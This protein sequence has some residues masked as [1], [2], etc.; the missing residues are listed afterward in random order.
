[1]NIISKFQNFKN[2]LLQISP[3]FFVVGLVLSLTFFLLAIDSVK[4][5]RSEVLILVNLKSETAI[6]QQEQLLDTIV[7]LPKTLAFYDQIL[8]KNKNVR[9]VSENLDPDKRKDS[10]NKMLSI[11]RVGKNSLIFKISISTKSASDSEQLSSKTVRELFDRIAF[12]YDIKKD[13]DLRIIEKP[14]ARTEVS[15]WPWILI[16]SFAGGFGIAIVLNSLLGPAVEK[17]TE[18]KEEN[19]S[20]FVFD[21]GKKAKVSVGQGVEKLR[22]LYQSDAPFVFEEK[23][24]TFSGISQIDPQLQEMKKLTKQME[25]SKYPNFPEMPVATKVKASAPDNLPIAEDDFLA[26]LPEIEKE[27][28]KEPVSDE[29]VVDFK[30]EPTKEELKER[31]NQLLRG[32]F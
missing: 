28:P 20:N 1:M 14:I 26:N 24:E 29:S 6:K 13:F 19:D 3:Q 10:W 16:V 5:Y 25:P 18:E 12:Y 31:L 21:F 17:R 11:S 22:R 32:E 23:K 8:A 2:R 9:D 4:T 27:I 7:E 15:A 30:R